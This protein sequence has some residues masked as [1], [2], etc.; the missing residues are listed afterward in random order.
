M[1][2]GHDAEMLGMWSR[3]QEGAGGALGRGEG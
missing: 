2:T 3:K 1:L